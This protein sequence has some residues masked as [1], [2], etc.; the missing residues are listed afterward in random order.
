M[1]SNSTIP[2]DYSQYDLRILITRNNDTDDF[3]GIARYVYSN[4]NKIVFLDGKP[5]MII[6][7]SFNRM[8]ILNKFYNWAINTERWLVER[9]INCGGIKEIED[10][11]SEVEDFT[12]EE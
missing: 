8:D 7:K 5:L 2:E 11:T 3:E 9:Y 10:F 4:N 12:N 6:E 1:K